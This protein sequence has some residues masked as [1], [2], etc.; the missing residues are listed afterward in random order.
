MTNDRK[1]NTVDFTPNVRSDFQTLS[2]KETGAMHDIPV[3][4]RPKLKSKSKLKRN[5]I[6]ST[7][8]GSLGS[9]NAMSACS[10]VDKSSYF[11]VE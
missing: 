3:I 10:A 8:L 1:V 2:L 5:I 6:A 7:D 9:W 11:S 4:H